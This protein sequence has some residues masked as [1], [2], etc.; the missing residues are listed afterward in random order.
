MKVRN[1]AGDEIEIVL[2]ENKKA[3]AVKEKPKAKKK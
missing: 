3:F 1:I 2:N